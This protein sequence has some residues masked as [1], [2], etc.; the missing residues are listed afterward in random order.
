MHVQE[1]DPT[2]I[3]LVVLRELPSLNDPLLCD[4]QFPDGMQPDTAHIELTSFLPL[5][6]STTDKP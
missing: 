1:Q 3:Y 5:S 2:Q 6:Y 4:V